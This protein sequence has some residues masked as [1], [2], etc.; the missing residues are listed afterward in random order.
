MKTKTKRLL[1]SGVAAAAI[2]S[3]LVIPQVQAGASQFLSL[4]RVDQLEMV[5]L[6]Q[7][8]ISEI[9]NW[10]HENQEGALDLKGIGKLEKSKA[11]GEPIYFETAESAESA[12]YPVPRIA[13]FDVIGVHVTPASNLTFTLNVEKANQLLTQLGSEHQ[14][15]ASLD[16]KSFSVSTFEAMKTDYK[17][18][19]QRISY[20]R[21]KSPEINVPEGVSVEQLRATLISLPFIPENVKTQLASIDKLETTLPIPIVETEGSQVSEVGVDGAQGF[22]VESEQESL[23]VWQENGE[24]HIIVFEGVMSPDELT[25]LAAKIN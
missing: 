9:E 16:G 21:T 23:I 10:I 6:T 12:G 24:I 5:K 13:E 1:I 18:K 3:S 7:S 11:I 17:L 8:D 15:E 2:F 25:Q 4:F 19:D 20:T 14:F 22:V